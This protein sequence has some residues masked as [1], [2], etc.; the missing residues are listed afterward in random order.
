MAGIKGQK[1]R[2]RAN[3]EGHEDFTNYCKRVVGKEPS[4]LSDAEFERLEDEWI[5][6]LK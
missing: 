1:W 2:V 5:C 3:P 6:R 4:E